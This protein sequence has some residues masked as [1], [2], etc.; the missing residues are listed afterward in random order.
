M[1]LP[2]YESPLPKGAPYLD[3]PAQI[4]MPQNE[5]VIRNDA[6]LVKK[7]SGLKKRFKRG[8]SLKFLMFSLDFLTKKKTQLE[9]FW[10][11]GEKEL[12]ASDKISLVTKLMIDQQ[13]RLRNTITHCEED[14]VECKKQLNS[15]IERLSKEAYERWRS[16]GKPAA[17]LFPEVD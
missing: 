13:K 11:K 7:D 9:K 6:G 10:T 5:F 3:D 14:I 4:V 8:V 2:I 15:R 1:S 17:R 16:E 12:E